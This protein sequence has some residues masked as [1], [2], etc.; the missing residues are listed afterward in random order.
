MAP[1]YDRPDHEEVGR[2][3]RRECMFCHNAYPEVPLGSDARGAPQTFPETLPEGTGCQRCHGPGGEH[4]ALA[5]RGADG[6]EVR[7]AIV[8]PAKLAPERR[9]DVCF[10]CH[11]QPSVA[12]PGT[13]RLGRADYSFR[14]GQALGDYVVPIDIDDGGPAAERFEINHHPYRLRSSRCAQASGP[15][16]SCL[17]CHD[18]HRKVPAAGRAAHYR[19]VCLGCHGAAAVETTHRAA[20]PPLPP[21]GADADCISCHMPRRRPRDVV[22]TVMTDH[23]IGV[24]RE[25][26]SLVAAAEEIEPRILDV[27]LYGLPPAPAGIAGDLYRALAAASAGGSGVPS[28]LDALARLAAARE[29]RSYEPYLELVP[30]LLRRGALEP[31]ERAIG[32]LLA[33]NPGNPLTLDWQSTL[34][35]RQGRLEEAE[36]LLRDLARR[37]PAQAETQFNLG[38]VLLARGKPIEARAALERAAA[39]RPNL[40]PAWFRLAEVCRLSG[41]RRAEENALRRALSVDPG[42]GESY[43]ALAAALVAQGRGDEA[44]A[45]IRFARTVARNAATLPEA[46]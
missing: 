40:V 17:T 45:W 12:I 19:A 46:D 36:T 24:Y 28:A 29:P 43:A 34:L 15:R 35:A 13:R 18:P 11:L 6:A 42:Q 23:R 27:R 44:A 16:L 32:H 30:A 20:S 41:D 14:P 21:L 2:R 26:A 39:L 8:N 33:A 5:M 38:R 1:G 9:D 31:A 7:A 10:Q 37:S 25:P 4:A 22:H 3:V